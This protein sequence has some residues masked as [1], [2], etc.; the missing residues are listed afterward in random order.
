LANFPAAELVT[1]IARSCIGE[2]NDDI[3]KDNGG[4][5]EVVY[6]DTD[7]AY[8]VLKKITERFDRDYKKI[9]TYAKQTAKKYSAKFPK[10]MVV[11]HE[12]IAVAMYLNGSKNYS[13][14]VADGHS[15]DIKD[16]TREYVEQ[17]N[18]IY[19]KGM[20]PA[21]KDKYAYNKRVMTEFLYSVLVRMDID[22]LINKLEYVLKNIWSMKTKVI[23]T[24]KQR[25]AL[26]S[27]YAYNMG[28]TPTALDGGNG[29]MA[30]WI[31][32]YENKYHQKPSAGERFKLLVTH[33]SSG[34]TTKSAT[35][36]STIDWFIKDNKTLNVEHY[37][38]CME[39]DGNVTSL[40][41][42]YA[43]DRVDQD[44]ISKYYM[45]NLRDYGQLHKPE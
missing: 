14:I 7:S 5:D 39:K 28:V 8:V 43:P 1:F 17:H 33:D 37:M 21:R 22:I 31:L 20:A 24:E 29:L 9:D 44:C 26:E 40:L 18:L 30:N 42:K 15:L 2:I 36:L 34:G 6:G 19:I 41:H 38:L 25:K 45:R 16:Y 23:S 12:R 10:P 13:L 27:N 4:L 32:L 11:E 35:R 3:G